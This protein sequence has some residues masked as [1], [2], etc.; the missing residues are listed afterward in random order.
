M[1][2]N[3]QIGYKTIS[4][5]NELQLFDS[6]IFQYIE[7][8]IKN[9][10]IKTKKFKYIFIKNFFPVKDYLVLLKYLKK[11]KYFSLKYKDALYD[12]GTNNY[13]ISNVFLLRFKD[14][15]IN[16]EK[17]LTIIDEFNETFSK[18]IVDIYLILD[19]TQ[20]L[21]LNLFYEEIKFRDSMILKHGFLNKKYLKYQTSLF[22][23]LFERKR[24][25]F[26]ILPH[27]HNAY[28]LIDCLFYTPEDDSNSFNGTSL[29]SPRKIIKIPAISFDRYI[30]LQIDDYD[31]YY[32]F[33][34]IPNSVVAWPNMP[35]S[36]HGSEY[37]N[38]KNYKQVLS[39]L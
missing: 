1:K 18:F 35:H 6:L 8:N 15:T 36:I 13:N 11:I 20:K 28:E 3:K 22:F 17:R 5:K 33:K 39:V 9:T 4:F 16:E 26:F 30:D 10:S 7:K 38:S 14:N 27:L 19:F 31:N 29:Y 21:L 25:D 24:T 12:D 32:T 34:Y 37:E 23:N 2:N